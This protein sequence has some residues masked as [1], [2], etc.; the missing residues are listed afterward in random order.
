[1]TDPKPTKKLAE[2]AI[3]DDTFAG[4]RRSACRSC[5]A[6]IRW[7]QTPAGRWTPVNED[8]TS[9]FATCPQGK[10]WSRKNTRKEG[11]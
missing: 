6:A 11:S 9:H 2:L 10:T 8:K 1:V 5:G 4:L 7:F 3:D